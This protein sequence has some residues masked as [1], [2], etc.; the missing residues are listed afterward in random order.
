MRR[1]ESL[2]GEPEAGHTRRD[3]RHQEDAGP[4]V[5]SLPRGE[6]SRDDESC[7]DPDETQENVKQRERGDA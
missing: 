7:E 6:A 4:A 5:E 3:G 2:E 1:Q